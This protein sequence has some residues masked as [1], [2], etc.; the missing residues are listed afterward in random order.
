[1]STPFRGH[2]GAANSVSY[3]LDG[4]QI[5]S[6]SGDKT[7]RIWDA[8]DGRC[9]VG[10][11]R[12]HMRGVK[13]AVFSPDGMRV[14]SGSEDMSVCVWDASTG[15]CLSAMDRGNWVSSIAF[16]LGCRWMVS[17]SVHDKTVRVEPV[18]KQSEER[19]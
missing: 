1:M 2:K 4:N 13:A 6:G 18:G 17:G 8:K 15:K 3:S 7:I 14:V 12:G 16:S 10:P 9:V 5:V 11:M 19:C